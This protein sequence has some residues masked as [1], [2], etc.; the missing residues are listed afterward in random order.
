MAPGASPALPN[1][2]VGRDPVIG[3]TDV[4][5]AS[6]VRGSCLGER[7]ETHV[8]KE[9]RNGESGWEFQ[10]L[11]CRRCLRGTCFG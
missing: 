5:V 2:A 11:S 10:C 7:P 4:A 6:Q 1:Q 3:P 8:S 9:T